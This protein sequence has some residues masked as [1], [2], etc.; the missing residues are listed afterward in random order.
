MGKILVLIFPKLM[1]EIIGDKG[2]LQ[3]THTQPSDH[4]VR[5]ELGIRIPVPIPFFPHSVQ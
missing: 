4:Y 2:L 5:L 3:G 1:P